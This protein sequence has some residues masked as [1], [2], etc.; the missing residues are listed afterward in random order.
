MEFMGLLGRKRKPLLGL[1]LSSSS[2]KLIELSRSGGRLKV[3]AYR[4]LPLPANAVVEKNIKD[5]TA[6][7]DTIR[8]VV[9][10]AKTGARDAAVAVAGSAAIT[11]VIDMPASLGELGLENQIAA[12]ADQYV[13][14]PLDEVALDYEVL[15]PSSTNPDQIEVMLAACRRENVDTRVAALEMAGLTP[16]VVD[17]EVFAVERA[18]RLISEQFE[19]IGDQVVAIADIGATMLTLSVLIDGKTLYTRE[20]LFGGKQVTEEIQRRYGLSMEEAGQAKRQGGLPE[21]YE[22]EILEPFKEALVQQVQRSLQFFF[23]SSQYNYVDHLVLAGGVAAMPGLRR[24]VEDKLGLPTTIAN[25]FANMAIG[26][27][28]NAVALAADAPAM[29]IAT[30]LALRGFD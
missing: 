8:R 24:E 20:Q 14:Y 9:S 27:G 18:F 22:T 10:A 3:E 25:P 16:R 13:P 19:D 15:G 6:V 29:L 30:G 21:D 28:V 26:G 11:K 1:D 2:V 4:V 12:E 7:A 23:S 17:I 5:V